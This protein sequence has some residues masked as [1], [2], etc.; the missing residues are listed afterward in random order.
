M[1]I[2]VTGALDEAGLTSEHN[3]S[4]HSRFVSAVR[5]DFADERTSNIDGW[6]LS[7]TEAQLCALWA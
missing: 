2:L 3:L 1:R 6:I 5:A 4:L 7:R